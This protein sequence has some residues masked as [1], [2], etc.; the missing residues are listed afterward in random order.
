MTTETILPPHT[1]TPATA[2]DLPFIRDSVARLRLDAE[3]LGPEPF[4]VVR[5]EGGDGIV[6]FGRIKPYQKTHELGSVAVIEGERGRGWGGLVVRELIRRFPQDEVFITTDL[7]EYFERL[8]LLAPGF[9]P[10][11]L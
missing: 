1:I 8:G 3:R 10:P 5:R 11:G 2:D 4:I 7:P 9:L 6:A